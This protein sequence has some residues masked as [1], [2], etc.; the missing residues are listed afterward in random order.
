MFIQL[1]Y[2]EFGSLKH[3]IIEELAEVVAEYLNL[4][5][6]ELWYGWWPELSVKLKL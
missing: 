1:K 2:M 4:C 3:Q 5:L 6:R